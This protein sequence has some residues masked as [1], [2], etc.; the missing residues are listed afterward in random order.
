[1][2]RNPR[3]IHLCCSGERREKCVLEGG[4]M[5]VWEGER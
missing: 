5:R 4:E 3:Y 2:A 1:M